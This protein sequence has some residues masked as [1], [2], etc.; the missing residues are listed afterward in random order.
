L[1]TVSDGLVGRAFVG[2]HGEGPLG[3][4]PGAGGDLEFVSQADLRDLENP[5]HVF[6]IP[7]HKRDEIVCGL[8]FPRFQRRGKG[9]G[10]S[11]TD[12]CNDVIKGRRIFR[13]CNHTAVFLLIEVLDPAVHAKMNGFLKVFDIG[14]TVRAFMLHDTD[15]T[16][17]S[18]GHWRPPGIKDR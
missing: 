16:G 11:P 15:V 8:D 18:N 1:N 17:V 4:V 14:H 10:Q 3:L 7:F 9:S 2:I 12:A 13:T 5:V 6:N